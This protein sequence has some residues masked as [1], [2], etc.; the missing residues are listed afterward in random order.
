MRICPDCQIRELEKRFHFCSECGEAR[1]Y[2]AQNIYRHNY[3]TN[4]PKKHKETN[5]KSCRKY[6]IKLRE[7]TA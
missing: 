5:I 6:K 3:K 1:R 4:N 2:I 7:A